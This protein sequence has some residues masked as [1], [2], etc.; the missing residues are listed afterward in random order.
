MINKQTDTHKGD[1]LIVDDDLPSLNTLSSMLTTEGYEVRGVPDGQMALTVIEN[2]PP[3]LIL[4]DVKMPEMNGFEVCQQIKADEKSSGIPILFLSALD[5]L[6]DK[7]KGFTVGAVDFITRPFQ[8]EEVLARVETHTTLYRLSKKLEEQVGESTAEIKQYKHIIET[9]AKPIGLVDRNFIYQYV[10]EPY[11]HAFK[12]PANEIIGHSV[13]ELFGRNFFETVMEHHYKRC[14]AGENVDYQEWFEFPGWGR[15]YMDVRYYP[16]KEADGRVTAVVTNVHDITEMK[17]LELKL[18]R[19]EE[20]FH[21]FM[22]HSPAV[23][24]IKN[25][26]GKHIYGNRALFDAFETSSD[27]FIGTTTDDFFPAD[28]AAKI[29]AY[30]REVLADGKIVESE[31][32]WEET[33]RQR[34]WWKEVKFPFTDYSGENMI[35]GLAFNITK[36]KQAEE[37]L[38]KAFAEIKELKNQ[39]EQE[40]IYLREEIEVNY[41]HEE[42]IGKCE[43]VMKMLSRAEQVA[44]TDAT[45]LLLGETGTGKELLAR[46]IHRMSSRKDRPM[47]KVNCGSLPATLIES[48]LFGRE[49]GA[50]TGALAKQAGRFEI[51]DG[52]TIF[53]DEIGD[54]PINLQVKLLRVLQEGQI[55]RLGSPKTITVNVRVIAATNKN[56]T[57]ALQEGRFRE[58]LFYRLNVFPI[59]VPPLRERLDDIP[60]LVSVFVREF[61]AKMA[62]KI[63]TITKNSINALQGYPW[64]GNVR[65]LHNVIEQ[66]MI[67]SKG[68]TL[69]IRSPAV[70]KPLKHKLYKLDDVERNHIL[71]TLEATGWRIKGKQGTAEILGLKPSTLHFRMKKLGI[72]RPTVSVNI[73]S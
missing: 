14:L 19:S 48:E 41:K 31:E 47:V 12:K 43:P 5:E 58:D 2:K 72:Q 49:K 10:N 45:V 37:K 60:L 25:A 64:P 39:I 69:V 22:D 62:K 61:E 16:L 11:C 66:A 26:S 71:K 67:I 44:E 13:P 6:E 46:A 50:Y 7:V 28:I 21:S 52:S 59:T 1:I 9:T 38:K 73:S 63:E 54:L 17:K 53:L 27:Q 35:G 32:F 57:A 15:R 42:I 8:A 56:L 18:Q 55:E 65:E 70:S 3:E 4:L 68:R 30:D 29:K 33:R 23:A 36:L 34:R 51:A 20:L 24:Y 40:N